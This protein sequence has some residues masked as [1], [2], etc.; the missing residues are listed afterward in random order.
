MCKC[1]GQVQYNMLIHRGRAER[2][3]ERAEERCRR[4]RLSWETTARGHVY[5]QDS[6]MDPLPNIYHWTWTISQVSDV[7]DRPCSGASWLLQKGLEQIQSHTVLR[8]GI[9]SSFSEGKAESIRHVF[10]NVPLYPIIEAKT[11]RSGVFFTV[12]MFN[13]LRTNVKTDLCL[14]YMC[15]RSKSKLHVFFS[16][17]VKRTTNASTRARSLD[18]DVHYLVTLV[19]PEH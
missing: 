15:T 14:A 1:A 18:Y 10:M 19:Y 13:H 12:S 2:L 4:E 8:P 6:C 3:G 9:D 16:K 11:D 5:I 7:M 17:L